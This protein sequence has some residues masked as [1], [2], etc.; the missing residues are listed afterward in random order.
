MIQNNHKLLSLPETLERM[1][2]HEEI[3][4]VSP[5]SPSSAVRRQQASRKTR[6]TKVTVKGE[7][8]LMYKDNNQF[9][10]VLM[11]PQTKGR[12][13]QRLSRASEA[14]LKKECVQM[15]PVVFELPKLKSQY[16]V[17]AWKCWIQWRQTQPNLATPR[18]ACM[19]GHTVNMFFK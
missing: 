17:E 8:H 9:D 16:G 10:C 3:S 7:I 19:S 11:S 12:I 4:Q 1:S 18:Y 2:W 6:E 13:P 14:I 5:S 15:K